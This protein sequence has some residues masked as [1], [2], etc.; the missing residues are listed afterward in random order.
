MLEIIFVAGGVL[1]IY[2]IR[3]IISKLNLFAKFRKSLFF[4]IKNV[5]NINLTSDD[6]IYEIRSIFSIIKCVIIFCFSIIAFFVLLV[7]PIFI[8][9]IL[10]ENF[11]NIV[12]SLKY[13]IIIL[14]LSYMHWKISK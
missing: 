9:I 4:I 11:I 7:S 14:V 6:E 13:N 5:R 2:F 10:N 3:K 12:I 1:Y 8:L